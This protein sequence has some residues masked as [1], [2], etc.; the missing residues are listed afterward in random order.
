[1]QGGFV[2]DHFLKETPQEF[3]DRFKRK[4]YEFTG[5]LFD[6]LNVVCGAAPII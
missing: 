5:K 1:M 3:E 6:Y 2:D 4:V